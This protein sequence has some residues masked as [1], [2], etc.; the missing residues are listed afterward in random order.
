[1][2]WVQ[3]ESERSV[4][5]GFGC[6]D[7]LFGA[8]VLCAESSPASVGPLCALKFITPAALLQVQGSFCEFSAFGLSLKEVT[9]KPAL[10]HRTGVLSED[11]RR[12]LVNGIDLNH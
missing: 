7:L 5:A 8:V 12:Q 10:S 11:P 3:T 2:D 1:M 9:D 6:G 4:Y